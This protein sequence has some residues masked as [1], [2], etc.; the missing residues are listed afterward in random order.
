MELSADQLL[1]KLD[2]SRS[3]LTSEE[4][5]RRLKT[6]GPNELAKRKRRTAAVEFLV[7]LGN[8]L[9]IIL[10][11]AGLISLSSGGTI[12]AI[13]IFSIVVLSVAL[14]IYQE[15]KAEKAAEMLKEKVTTTATVI[16]DGAKQEVKLS[17]I[18]PG[19]IVYLS[20]G[21]IIPA[22]ARLI[23]AKDLYADQSSLTG[24]SFPVEKTA[25]PLKTKGGTITE[26]D[27]YLF[28]G[29]SVVS[30]AATAVVAKT[31][32][33]TE[34]GQIAQKLVARGPETEY[35]RGLRRFGY[36]MVAG[37][38]TS[39]TIRILHQRIIQTWRLG[40]ASFLSSLGC[41]PDAGTV[42]NDLVHKPFKRCRCDVKERRCCKTSRINRESR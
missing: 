35:E 30:G 14:D 16:R 2:T 29:T 20:A 42:T 5:G 13:I 15:D 22:D 6:Y 32:K 21:D 1:A 8:P 9:V 24:E 31:G 27:N 18:V 41:R 37:H 28:L 7:H 39:R 4:V 19:D 12:D 36:L 25:A 17:E 10:L 11:L 40:V 26:W 3:G 23:D 38:P 34:Y 33:S